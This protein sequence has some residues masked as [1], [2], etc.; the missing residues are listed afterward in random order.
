MTTN[1][2]TDRTLRTISAFFAAIGDEVL[3]EGPFT[4]ADFADVTR[5]GV[6]II[7]TDGNVHAFTF[8]AQLTV[9]R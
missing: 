4:I 5:L 8:D 1:H 3:T 6:R 2:D 9:L 7:D